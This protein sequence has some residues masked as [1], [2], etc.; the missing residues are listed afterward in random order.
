MNSRNGLPWGFWILLAFGLMVYLVIKAALE[1]RDRIPR[2]QLEMAEIASALESYRFRF[3]SYPNGDA[4][5]I[6]SA[7]RGNNPGRVVFFEMGS[8]SINGAGEFV[9]PWRMS[10]QILINEETN[11]V[12]KSAGRDGKFGDSD[13]YIYDLVSRRF[14]QQPRIK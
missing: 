5:A 7:L 1:P 10:Y 11:A 2:V 3:D 13:D 9:D 12:I 4:A 14:V 8:N 6:L